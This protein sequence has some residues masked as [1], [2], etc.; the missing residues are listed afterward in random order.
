[1]QFAEVGLMGSSVCASSCCLVLSTP[2]VRSKYGRGTSLLPH[3][4]ISNG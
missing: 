3:P 1:M 2:P 4:V